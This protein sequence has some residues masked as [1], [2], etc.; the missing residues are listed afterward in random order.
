[1]KKNKKIILSI[2]YDKP[3]TLFNLTCIKYIEGITNK[4]K[5]VANDK[6]KI[7]AQAIGPKNTILSPPR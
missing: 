3:K 4:V 7:I 6:P 2:S 5:K 1:V